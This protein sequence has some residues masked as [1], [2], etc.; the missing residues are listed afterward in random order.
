MSELEHALVIGLGVTG[1]AVAGAL[2]RRGID[3][4]VV[5]D[6]PRPEHRRAAESLGVRLVESP[7][8]ARLQELLRGTDVML[9]SPG[10]P[11]HHRAF[12][13]AADLRVPAESEFDLAGRWDSRPLVAVTGTDG[14]TT[15]TTMVT[16]MLRTSGIDAVAAGNTEVPLVAAIDAPGTELFVVEASS[17]RLAHTR[18]FAPVVATWLNFGADHQDAH[19]S[20]ARYEEAKARIWRDLPPGAVVVANADDPVVM[21]HVDASMRVVTFGMRDADFRVDDGLLVAGEDE[22]VPVHELARALPHDVLNGLA[23]AATAL[24]A[25]ADMSAVRHVLATFE[26]LPHRVELV[27]RIDGVDYYDDS[28]ATAPHATVAALAGFD[29]VVLIAGGRNKGL[30]LSSIRQGAA[31]V[32]G[33]VA[34]GEATDEVVEV[35]DGLCPVRTAGSMREAVHVAAAMAQ[36]ADVVLLSPACASFDWYGSYAERGA[37]FV[38]AV[39][40]LRRERAG[41]G[42]G[43]NRERR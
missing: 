24:G 9:P 23:A 18:H 10:V 7:T 13:L 12:A 32:R 16:E 41:Q 6:H 8:D 3:V 17:F 39:E 4:V 1:Q 14:K 15:V 19:E 27:A 36:P 43:E 30:D 28:K 5:E 26:G 11:D 2:V 22:L 21:R 25:G 31:G 33:V 40:E 20:L 35:F 37:D 34:I 29:S 42:G 38:D